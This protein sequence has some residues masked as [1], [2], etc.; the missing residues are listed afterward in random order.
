MA[1]AN[2]EIYDE[3]KPEQA[4]ELKEKL[5]RARA[6]Q[7]IIETYSQEQIDKLCQAIAW[8]VANKETF[9]LNRSHHDS[10]SS[11]NVSI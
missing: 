10:S 9:L 4:A 8:S 5:R 7:K 2:P 11:H 1:N 6:A 3:L